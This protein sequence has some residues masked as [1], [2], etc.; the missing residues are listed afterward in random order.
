MS[1]KERYKVV[2]LGS[3]PA[4]LTAAIYASRANLEPLVVEGGGGGDQ[5]DLPGGQLMLTTDVD[6]YP[7]F[8][9][10]IMGPE[11]DGRLPPPGRAVRHGLH[12]GHASG[13]RPLAAAVPAGARG[14]DGD[15]R[16]P[17]RRDRRPRQVAGARERDRLP[18]ERRR[19]LG[20][21]DLRRVLLQGQGRPGGGRRRHRDGGGDLPHQVREPRDGRPPAAGAARL[22]DHGGPRPR[23][24]EDRLAA[25]QRGR[26][27]TSATTRRSSPARGSAT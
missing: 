10:G 9:E 8:P 17:R 20:L 7:G 12:R 19:R 13:G 6:N 14:G 21:R 23:E 25:R 5:T 15:G 22:E 16:R 24:P 18:H 27:A 4:G 26:R 3:G 1:L 2:I 11:P